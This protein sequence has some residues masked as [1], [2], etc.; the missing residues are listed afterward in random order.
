MKVSKFEDNSNDC[1]IN[2]KKNLIELVL[3][4]KIVLIIMRQNVVLHLPIVCPSS[5]FYNKMH[6]VS[7]ESTSDM[8]S[9]G[10]HLFPM[11]GHMA[12]RRCLVYSTW[13]W[14]SAFGKLVW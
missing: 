4:Q 3:H 7:S 6:S 13:D 2:N 1:S 8:T 5:S 12:K 9:D 11:I 14:Y 10:E